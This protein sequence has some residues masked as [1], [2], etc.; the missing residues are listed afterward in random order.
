[1]YMYMYHVCMYVC[2]HVHVPCVY[3]CMFTCTCTM[4]VCMYVYMYMYMYM[5]GSTPCT[6]VGRSGG[7]LRKSAEERSEEERSSLPCERHAAVDPS[8]VVLMVATRSAVTEATTQADARAEKTTY[9]EF[10]SS[11]T[12]SPP[13]LVAWACGYVSDKL[14]GY[15]MF[16]M[17]LPFF[18]EQGVVAM[19]GRGAWAR[20][21]PSGVGAS[22]P[23]AETVAPPAGPVGT[24]QSTARS[25][26]AFLADL[27]VP[28][29]VWSG[30]MLLLF[31]NRGETGDAQFYSTC[32][33]VYVLLS[34]AQATMKRMKA[35]SSSS[36][37]SDQ[38][39]KEKKKEK[40]K[41]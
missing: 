11:L 4:C 2:L 35:R 5:Y 8:V 14:M 23:P 7:G 32:V 24:T 20:P 33:G 30:P 39:S 1:M 9:E 25:T 26:G 3:V 38:Q 31:A 18:V 15:V 13:F 37:E 12:F 16:L 34:A 27:W 41:K 29:S 40:K 36:I 19:G 17:V 28:F 6:R 10:L 22:G 21:Q